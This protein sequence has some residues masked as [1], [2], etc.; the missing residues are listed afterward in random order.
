MHSRKTYFESITLLLNVL[1]ENQSSL[2]MLRK[3]SFITSQ[4]QIKI[5]ARKIKL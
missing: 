3:L 2:Y 4:I 1:I 5:K